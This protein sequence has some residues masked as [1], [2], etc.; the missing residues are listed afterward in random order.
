[1]DEEITIEVVDWYLAFPGKRWCGT[2]FLLV[3]NECPP[4]EKGRYTM[5]NTHLATYL[6][7]HLA[8]ATSA[9]EFLTHL[10]EAHAGTLMGDFLTHL[11]ADIGADHQELRHLID[12][13]HIA[14]SVPRKMGAWLGEKAAQ[15][16]LQIDDKAS[17]SFRLF[18]GLEALVVGIEGKRGLWRALAVAS[19]NVPELQGVD[20][21]RLAQRALEQRDGVD[22][23]RLAA[24]K[25]AL[26]AT[27]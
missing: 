9:L 6:N 16:K 22:E 23:R 13:L 27:D 25:E 15:L 2:C 21:A 7:D 4:R 19:E 11:H 14:E 12:R 5:A 1:M 3:L 26:A 20:Y 18:E 10:E 8:G 24:A 17:G